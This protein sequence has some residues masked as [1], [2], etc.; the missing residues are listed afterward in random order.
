MKIGI[1]SHYYNSTNYGGNLQAYALC[2][3]LRRMGYDSEQICFPFYK[4]PHIKMK[5]MDKLSIR[6]KETIVYSIDW[7]KHPVYH[8]KLRIRKKAMIKFRNELIPHSKEIF[9][10]K[11]LSDAID[12]YQIFITGSDIVWGPKVHSPF[13]FLNFVPSEIPK[14]SYA[15]SL[16]TNELTEKEKEEFKRD[17]SGYQDISVREVTVVP[18]LAEVLQRKISLC[19]DPTLLFF[20]R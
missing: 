3:I 12:D 19:V 7:I 8:N 14:F 20:R 5:I 2:E 9:T 15:A 4:N 1:V 16:G 18:M 6:I 11:T 13:F 17:L 10:M